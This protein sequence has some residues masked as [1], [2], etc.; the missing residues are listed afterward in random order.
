MSSLELKS[1]NDEL[2]KL[3]NNFKN[4]AYD[5]YLDNFKKTLEDRKTCLKSKKCAFK[6]TINQSNIIKKNT[7]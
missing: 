2:L 5:E 4:E 6:F 1:E 3:V 7:K